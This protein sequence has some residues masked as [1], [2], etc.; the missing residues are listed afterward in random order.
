MKVSIAIVACM[1]AVVIFSMPQVGE[2]KLGLALAPFVWVANLAKDAART[3]VAYKLSLATKALTMI[4][5]N[6][7]VRTVISY[8][9]QLEH[10]DDVA[11]AAVDD[12]EDQGSLKGTAAVTATPN[13]VHGENEWLPSVTKP[14]IHLSTLPPMP[15]V[16]VPEIRKSV[17]TKLVAPKI[18]VSKIVKSKAHL[19][20]NKLTKLVSKSPAILGGPKNADGYINGGFRIGQGTDPVVGAL[21]GSD[22]QTTPSSSVDPRYV[23]ILY[24]SGQLEVNETT[25][26]A[27]V[28]HSRSIRSIDSDVV[29]RYFQFIQSNDQGR[30]VALMVCS[31][32]AHPQEFGA[33][34]RNVV[35]FFD[36][37]KPSALSPMAPYKEASRIG[38]SG[39]SCR[40]RYS[41]CQ[42]DPK[43]LA[44]LG[45]SH[46]VYT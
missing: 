3:L 39:D 9:S 4:T 36:D 22:P 42:V 43:Y 24:K 2:A 26:M 32:A 21:L 19:L 6:R 14:G 34:G 7:A 46:V 27:P 1:V 13:P 8:D 33:Y 25:D 23:T 16:V 35:A 30:C 15:K 38:R 40:S 12:G 44:Q 18:V 11:A 29:G 28:N 20:S 5:G 17:L 31:M 41:A 45:E 37:V 10:Y